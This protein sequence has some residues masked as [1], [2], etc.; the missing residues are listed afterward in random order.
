MYLLATPFTFFEIAIFSIAVISFLFTL[1][2]FVA[3]QK[4]LESLLPQTK[5]KRKRFRF[6]IDRDGFVVPATENGRSQTP[7]RTVYNSVQDE[8]TKAE[9]KELRDLLQLQQLE[10]SRALEKMSGFTKE[11]PFDRYNE[12][13]EVEDEDVHEVENDNDNEQFYTSPSTA[14]LESLRAELAKKDEELRA[15]SQERELTKKLQAHFE[16]VQAGY[17]E[18]QEKVQKME[19]QAWQAAELSIKVDGL[20]QAVAQAEKN[21]TKKDDK[22]RE[23]TVENGR[24]HEMLNQTE[25]KLSE[26]NLQRQQLMKKVHF[27]E[28]INNDIQQMSDTNRK[29]KN[30]LRRVAELESMLH[31]ITEERDALLKRRKVL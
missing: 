4:K 5:K 3:S 1:R 31:L 20:E 22:L 7:V 12:N 19:Q 10:L 15:Y 26:A 25:D 13:V 17:D 8:E 16:D 11:L 27:L 28:E 24:L 9:I 6:G 18:L 21:V 29:L 14:E 2:F 23:L 30:E